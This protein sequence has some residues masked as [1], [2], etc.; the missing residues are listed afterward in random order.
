MTIVGAI[1]HLM[2]AM[3]RLNIPKRD[4]LTTRSLFPICKSVENSDAQQFLIDILDTRR[5]ADILRDIANLKYIFNIDFRNFTHKDCQTWDDVMNV[6]MNCIDI[7]SAETRIYLGS[8]SSAMESQLKMFSD[9]LSNSICV[10]PSMVNIKCTYLVPDTG[11]TPAT[12][13]QVTFAYGFSP[14]LVI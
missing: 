5:T 1:E 2:Q 4:Y 14:A 3:D 10:D 13:K 9:V 11:E 8:H 6:L 12:N 7:M